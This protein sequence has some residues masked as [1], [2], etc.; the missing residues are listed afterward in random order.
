MAQLYIFKNELNEI[1]E[2]VK[3]EKLS[4]RRLEDEQ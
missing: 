4:A 2:V 1:R 3:Q